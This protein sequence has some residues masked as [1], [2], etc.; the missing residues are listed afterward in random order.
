MHPNF[1]CRD[2]EGPAYHG[3]Y[4]ARAEKITQS[5]EE[6]SVFEIMIV[7]LGEFFGWNNQ[8]DGNKLVTFSLKSRYDLRNLR[9]KK[10]RKRN[11]S[12]LSTPLQMYRDKTKESKRLMG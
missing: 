1:L 9:G 12:F 7:L 2:E 10:K 3:K 4:R 5:I 6:R 8:L 11:T